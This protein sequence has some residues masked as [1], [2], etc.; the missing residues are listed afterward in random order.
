MIAKV[1]ET[2]MLVCFGIAWPLSIA[3]SWKSRTARG[4]SVFFLFSVLVGY[5]AGFAKA[6]LTD[7]WGGFLLIPYGINFCMVAADIVLYFRNRRI[8]LAEEAKLGEPAKSDA[9]PMS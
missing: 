9:R 5:V 8:D 6:V 3:R 1:L 2:L 7:G 4:K